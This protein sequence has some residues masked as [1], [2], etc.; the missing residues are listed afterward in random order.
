[1]WLVLRHSD[2]DKRFMIG[3]NLKSRNKKLN[4]AGL[5]NDNNNWKEYIEMNDVNIK[6]H[7]HIE[8]CALMEKKQDL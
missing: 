3:H 8:T 1:M 6:H 7:N 5:E 2:V 4:N